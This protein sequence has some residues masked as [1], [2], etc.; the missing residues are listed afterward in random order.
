MASKRVKCVEHILCDGSIPCSSFRFE[1]MRY[2]YASACQP[3]H[4][5]RCC[6]FWREVGRYK[7]CRRPGYAK[8]LKP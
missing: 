4:C 1:S 5:A 3:D 2:G 7:R 8:H 6:V